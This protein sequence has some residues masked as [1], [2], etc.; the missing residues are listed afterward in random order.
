MND[1]IHI[2]AAMYTAPHDETVGMLQIQIT[3]LPV[4]IITPLAD[5]LRKVVLALLTEK[6][7][8]SGE[9]TEIPTVPPGVKLN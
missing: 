9:I 4:E 3:P 7:I 6:Q 1:G 5:H 2:R 8:T